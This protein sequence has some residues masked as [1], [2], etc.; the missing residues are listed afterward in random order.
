MYYHESSVVLF[1]ILAV[2]ITFAVYLILRHFC[3]WYWKI[4]RRIELMEDMLRELRSLNTALSGRK[5]GDVP[6]IEDG[7]GNPPAGV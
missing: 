7:N 6:R 4:N 2:L 5:T 3:C 1:A